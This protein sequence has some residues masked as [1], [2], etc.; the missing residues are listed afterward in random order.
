MGD[1]VLV[2]TT[3]Q[4]RL[5]FLYALKCYGPF[6]VLECFG[7]VSYNITLPPQSKINPVFH[8][9][10]LKKKLGSISQPTVTLPPL[11]DA[12]QFQPELELL[13]HWKG[14]PPEEATWES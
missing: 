6:R 5:L 11:K 12:G 14:M 1:W 8:V 7:P 2:S 10:L 9:S 4:E 3:L 13:V